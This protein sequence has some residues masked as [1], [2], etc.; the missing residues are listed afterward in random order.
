MGDKINDSMFDVQATLR[1]NDHDQSLK[2]APSSREIS[3]RLAALDLALL[4]VIV[5]RCFLIID[6]RYTSLKDRFVK[7]DD[8]E[9]WD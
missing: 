9:H 6:L 4:L 2:Y 7:P 1:R 3:F 8:D 5:F